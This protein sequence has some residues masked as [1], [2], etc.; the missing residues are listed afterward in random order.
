[1][2]KYTNSRTQPVIH[3]DQIQIQIQ[4]QI[5]NAVHVSIA[6]FFLLSVPHGSGVSVS[7]W[8]GQ[9]FGVAVGWQETPQSVE[10][11]KYWTLWYFW[12][13]DTLLAVHFEKW[14]LVFTLHFT[15]WTTFNMEGSLAT[16]Y[17]C[18]GGRCQGTTLTRSQLNSTNNS[19]SWMDITQQN[20]K[21]LVKYT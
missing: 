11:G 8:R 20:R 7:V 13:E 10:P 5:L 4:I 15:V 1:M 16:E 17:W 21:K 3:S 9:N 18:L 19:E 12:V 14:W 6:S 2:T